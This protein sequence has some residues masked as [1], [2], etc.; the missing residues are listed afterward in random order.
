MAIK[1]KWNSRNKMWVKFDDEKKSGIIKN[2]RKKFP[3]IPVVGEGKKKS[4]GQKKKSS[5][6]KDKQG[7]SK[8]SKGRSLW[9]ILGM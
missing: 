4:N 2:S 6:G 1:Q 5:E 7:N 8:N 9:D 3:D